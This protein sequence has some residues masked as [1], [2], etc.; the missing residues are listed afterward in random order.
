[1]VFYIYSVAFGK[2]YQVVP[3]KRTDRLFALEVLK[4]YRISST[5]YFC[6]D[7]S[8]IYFDKLVSA[9]AAVGLYKKINHSIRA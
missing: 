5:I 1:M 8:C 3:N 7:N 6:M 4:G 9:N 2:N